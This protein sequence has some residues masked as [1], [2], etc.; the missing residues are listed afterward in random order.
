MRA[1]SCQPSVHPL[2]NEL[3][4]DNFERPKIER[5]ARYLKSGIINR[6]PDARRPTSEV[7]R[8]TPEVP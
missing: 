1:I 8:Q 6:T 7:R 3:A 4:E 5:I 2:F